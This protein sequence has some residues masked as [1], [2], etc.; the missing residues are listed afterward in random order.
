MVKYKFCRLDSVN[1]YSISFISVFFTGKILLKRHG[2][3]AG[4]LGFLQKWGPHWSLTLPFEPFRLWLRIRGDIRSR[5]TTPRLGESANGWLGESGSRQLPD[6]PS[7][8]VGF[9]ML[10]RKLGESKSRRLPDSASPHKRITSRTFRIRGTLI[11][12][13]YVLTLGR[14]CR[15]KR[16][17]SG[18][19]P[20]KVQ[21]LY[22]IHSSVFFCTSLYQTLCNTFL[23]PAMWHLIQQ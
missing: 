10:K 23:F 8:R 16:S 17:S 11:V 15:W 5:K 4:F 12:N 21:A 14:S 20:L 19:D 9:W 1:L 13:V 18:G 7:R 22:P 3:E 2:N 6:L